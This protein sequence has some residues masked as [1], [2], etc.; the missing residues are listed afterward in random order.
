M[1]G[2]IYQYESPIG[3]KYIGQTL[4]LQRKR[5][6]KHKYDAYT[7]RLDT[8]FA[9]AIRKYSWEEIRPT[10]RVI[11]I[12]EAE[13]RDELKRLLTERENHYID[14]FD[15][16]IPNGYNVKETNQKRF[17][18]YRD[19]KGMYKKISKSLK[20]K[21]LNEANPNSRRIINYDTKEIYPSIS[22]ASRQTGILVASICS[23]LKSKNM[24]SGGYR[25]C[26]VNED[27]TVDES[28]LRPVNRKQLPLYCKELDRT[29][30]SAYEAAKFIG[31]PMGKANIR[32]AAEK[33]VKRYGLTFEYVDK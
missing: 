21:Y 4:Y 15:T 30:V 29:F 25:W 28:N 12:I 26:Y 13:D 31:K 8:P 33:G 19:K 27:G 20:G 9:R 6:D 17:G 3:K 23:V 24:K 11:E 16:M 10:Y 2:V 1:T 18:V 22:E 5:I 32:T 7:N 14:H